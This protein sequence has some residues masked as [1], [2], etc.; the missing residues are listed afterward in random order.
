MIAAQRH[1]DATSISVIATIHWSGGRDCQSV[2]PDTS[3]R[4]SGMSKAAAIAQ[5]MLAHEEICC[6]R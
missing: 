3:D 2:R 5:A 4:V 1:E 6:A